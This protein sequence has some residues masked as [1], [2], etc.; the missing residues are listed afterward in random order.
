MVATA[1]SGVS[2]RA[3]AIGLP[4][5]ASSGSLASVSCIAAGSCTAVGNDD[6]GGHPIVATDTSGTWSAATELTGT[7]SLAGISCLAGDV[8]SAVGSDS[9]QP[10]AMN[11]TGGA[12]TRVSAPT[13]PTG[14][15]SGTLTSVACTTPG[16][17]V[18][19]GNDV[20]AG[21][22]TQAMIATETGG[23]WGQGAQVALPAGAA[24]SPGATLNAISCPTS[25]H[26]VAVG[27]YVNDSGQTAALIDTQGGT[28]AAALALPAG[29]TASTLDSI[30]CRSSTSCTATGSVVVAGAIAPLGATASGGTWSAGTALPTPSGAVS[31]GTLS[32]I[33]LALGCTAAEQCEAA[34]TTPSPPASA[35]WGS[36]RIRAL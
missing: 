32:A 28:Q 7:G 18:A 30:S 26:C 34:G 33:A 36:A 22:H 27:S 21:G 1:A 17:C 15:T 20:D 10:I 6:A 4:S 24:A 29:A 14:A 3:A 35:R 16:N 19:G 23:I 9:G 5:G 8:C 11:G 2:G 31:S 13:L 25:G 12:L